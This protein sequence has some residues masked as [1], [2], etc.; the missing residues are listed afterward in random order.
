[1][2]Y[3]IP[4]AGRSHLYTDEEIKAVTQLLQSKDKLTQGEHL[5]EFEKSFADY[6]GVPRA[7]ACASAATALEMAAQ[8]SCLNEGDEVVC[9][10]HTYTASAYP[11]IKAGGTM[12][13]ADI[14]LETR[15]VSLETL[16]ACVTPRTRV[17]IVVYL[18]GY[19][20]PDIQEIRTF[21]DER[22]I[23][24]VEDVAQAIGTSCPVTSKKAGSFGDFAVF[25][26]HSHK[27]IS[28]LGEGGMLIVKDEY[29]ASILPQVRH[30][31]HAAFPEPRDNYWT[32]AMGNV[33][34]PKVNGRP[35]MPNN[36]CLNEAACAIG[37]QLLKRLDSINRN[38]RNRALQFIDKVRE[39]TDRISFH[40][41][42]DTSHNYHLL[43]AQVHDGKRD[44]LMRTLAEQFGIQCVVQYY[45]LYRYD[46]Y[47]D[48]GYSPAECP[49]T[50]TFFDNMISFPFNSLYDD[51]D[52][53][54]VCQSL[55]EA[56]DIVW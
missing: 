13:W 26:F 27:N 20:C 48:L 15:V 28:T 47:R 41:I 56:V 18:Y 11:F 35:L 2:A 52:L 5:A 17:I 29:L 33:V 21:C 44:T 45:P 30:N 14:N 10:G 23:M 40:R 43:V 16:K 38:K 50:D 54:Y 42:D 36:F 49:A 6:I 9:P 22:N 34:L 31:G 32:P 1:M 37:T 51:E 46:L 25:S 3:K 19:M 12:V 8:L 39:K 24:L 55:I 7:F 4:F 53:D